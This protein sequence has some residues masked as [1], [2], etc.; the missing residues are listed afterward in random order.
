MHKQENAYLGE[1]ALGL[2]GE[3]ARVVGDQLVPEAVVRP[4]EPLAVVVVALIIRT[5]PVPPLPLLLL[6]R[7]LLLVTSHLRR[8]AVILV[9]DQ[10]LLELAIERGD[11][12][13]SHV[14]SLGHSSRFRLRALIALFSSR[15]R[16]C[17]R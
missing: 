5:P 1:P 2:V 7:C 17:G 3:L 6:Q 10:L 4:D 11:R 13:Y 14:L 9:Q 8:R 12:S 16:S 15:R